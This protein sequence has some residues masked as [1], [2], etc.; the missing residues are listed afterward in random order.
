ME[1]R[2]HQRIPLA[3]PIRLRIS[4]IDKFTEEYAADLSAGGIFLPMGSPLQ[5]ETR[6]AL[7]FYLEPVEKLI[8]TTGRVVRSVV[9]GDEGKGR[10]G[11]GIE[12]LDLDLQAK[13]FIE[14]MVKKY[15]RQHPN[16]AIE[17]PFTTEEETAPPPTGTPQ[18]EAPAA[19][20]DTE[21]EGEVEVIAAEEASPARFDFDIPEEILGTQEEETP[22][23]GLDFELPAG[24][25]GAA[26]QEAPPPKIDLQVRVRYPDQESFL[27]EQGHTLQ[28]GEIFVRSSA[29]PAAGTMLHLM[30]FLNDHNRWAPATGEVV[31]A[32][33]SS[34]T[35]GTAPGPG[36]AVAIRDPSDEI[37]QLLHPAAERA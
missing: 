36:I 20:V 12:F 35:A 2:K 25:L 29:M 16:D 3:F 32:M 22:P 6:L 30:I 34:G 7:E 18:E 8:K 26:E 23:A 19:P 15:N 17:L 28:N 10:P 31:G 1:R 27:A 37:D 33:Y 9:E 4:D 24:I 5:V 13:R 14:L 11:M 21:P